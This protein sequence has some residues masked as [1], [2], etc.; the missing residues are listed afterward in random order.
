MITNKSKKKLKSNITSGII[1]IYTS[2]NNSIVTVTDFHGNTIA[3]SSCGS[4]DFKGSKKGIPFAAQ[5]ATE[6]ACKKAHESGLKNVE[7]R[8]KGPGAG[9]E[10]AL[11]AISCSGLKISQ[12]RDVTPMP[13]NGCRSPKRRRV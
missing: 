11:R 2:F 12:I 1:H 4:K 13:H 10:S 9:R 3:W 6:D 7:V 5:V 8:I